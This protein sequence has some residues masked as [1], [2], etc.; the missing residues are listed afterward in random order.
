MP[1][2][3]K[4]TRQGAPRSF[5][6]RLVFAGGPRNQ[7]RGAC[8]STRVR[9]PSVIGNIRPVHDTPLEARGAP[10]RRRCRLGRRNPG[11]TIPVLII[12][13]IFS[14]QGLIQETTGAQGGCKFAYL[15]EQ[16]PA[17]VSQVI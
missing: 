12:S 9:V 2:H 8:A 6:G 7:P 4:K 10:G 13:P 14:A 1:G 11:K 17:D 16:D 3:G 15:V 5:D